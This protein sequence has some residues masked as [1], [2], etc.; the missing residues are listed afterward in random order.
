MGAGL[1]FVRDALNNAKRNRNNL[2]NKPNF[3]QTYK[4]K[5]PNTQLNYRKS[6]PEELAQ[7]KAEFI[8]KQKLRRRKDILLFGTIILGLVTLVW[9]LFT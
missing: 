9:Y 5:T 2:K 7:F 8:Q 1:G 3:K 4:A 6:S